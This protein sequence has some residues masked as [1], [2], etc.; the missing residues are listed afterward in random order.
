VNLEL[1]PACPAPAWTVEQL[2]RYFGMI[3]AERILR[4]PLPGSA[5]E[6]DLIRLNEHKEHLYELVDGVLLEK[7]MGTEEGLRGG[8]LVHLL[9]SFLEGRDFGIALPGDAM[10]RLLPGLIRVPDVSFISAKRLVGGRLPKQPVAS[11][12][13][14]LAVEVVSPGNTRR[15][16]ER[17][18]REYFASGTRLAWVIYPKTRTVYVYTCPEKEKRLS[19]RQT[20]TG[21]SVLPGFRLPLRRLF[22]PGSAR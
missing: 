5:T 6:K 22:T 16:I 10:L 7:A 18:L 20:L 21:G 14:D 8:W 4:D 11:I 17:K 13:P 2:R 1:P 15:E 3:P 19:A 9:W 12:A